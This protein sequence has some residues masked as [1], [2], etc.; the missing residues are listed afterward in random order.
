MEEVILELRNVWKSYGGMPV[1][2]GV[3]LRLSKGSLTV[4]RGRSGAG[5]STLARIAGLLTKP[6]KGE[7]FFNSSSVNG[8][9]DDELA[10]LRLNYVGFVFQFFNLIPT[11]TVLENV[12]LPLAIVGLSSSER[13][14]RALRAL[15]ELG[16]EE[17]ANRFP[18]TLSG[19]ER[20]RVAIARAIVNSPK[21][22]IAD[23]P[24]SQL[25]D[26]SAYRVIELIRELNRDSDITVLLT[27][28]ELWGDALEGSVEY[29]LK[30][31]RLVMVSE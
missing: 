6:D 27:T 1:L 17:L 29:L 21:I 20:Q 5:K 30:N 14:A 26:E 10:S 8:L 3:N 28:T 4:V 23:E 31:G 24:T 9:S 18:E 2:K 22:L 15:R 19:G 12:E 25:D 16:V 7:I 11:L 13:R